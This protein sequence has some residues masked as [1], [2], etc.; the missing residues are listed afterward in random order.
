MRDGKVIRYYHTAEFTT[1]Q[2]LNHQQDMME[3]L[4]TPVVIRPSSEKISV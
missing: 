2:L 1:L 3:A 4:P